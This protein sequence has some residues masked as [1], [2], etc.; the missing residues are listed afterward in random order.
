VSAP[1]K[2]SLALATEALQ[3][4]LKQRD[5]EGV[6]PPPR[7]LAEATARLKESNDKLA[8]EYRPERPSKPPSA[9]KQPVASVA[10]SRER[11]REIERIIQERALLSAFGVTPAELAA[12][13][14]LAKKGADQ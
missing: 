4:G 7:D 3:R 8:I 2:D 9:P 14:S 1:A 11:A 5:G 12:F 10:L 13:C 6:R